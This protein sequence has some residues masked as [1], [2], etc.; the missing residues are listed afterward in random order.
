LGTGIF[1]LA[2]AKS[3]IFDANT[4]QFLGSVSRPAPDSTFWI[5]LMRAIFAGW[6]IAIMVWL[7]PAAESAKVS[8]II[9]V[10]Y[11]I[12][13]GGFN[14]VIAGSTKMFYLIFTGN[15]SWGYYF[16]Y[17]LVPTLMGNIV[18]GVSLV[19]FLGHAQVVAGKDS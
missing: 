18:G 5:V 10:T 12:G 3:G 11:L 16:G 8:I 13:L 7:L 2:I 19:A 1:A 14:H 4:M 15:L 9:I 17:F 6:L